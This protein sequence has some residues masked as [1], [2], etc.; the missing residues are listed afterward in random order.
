MRIGII[1]HNYP[2]NKDDR[3][4]AGIF[5]YD[6]AEALRNLGHDV[7]VLSCG[8]KAKNEKDRAPVSWFTWPGF[9]KKLGKLKI[10][11]PGDLIAFMVMLIWGC[12]QTE[13]FIQKNKIDFVIGMWTVPA[14]LFS[15]WGN[16]R[17]KTHYCLW[18]LGSDTY[19]YSRYPILGNL[20]KLSLK[21]AIF[22]LADGID[23]AR[24]TGQIANRP[25]Q[26]LPSASLMPQSEALKIKKTGPVKFMFL[27]RIESV[28]GPDI[29]INTFVKLKD[30]DFKLHCLGDGSLLPTLKKQVKDFGLEKKVIFYGNVNDPKIIQKHLLSSDWLIIPSRGDSIPLVFSES[31]KAGLPVVAAEV[32]DLTELINKYKVGFS[33]PKEDSQ[34]LAEILRNLINKG[35]VATKPYQQRTKKASLIFDINTS[36]RSLIKT[37]LPYL[38]ARQ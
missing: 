18:S 15:L 22:L 16:L 12:W 17:R 2:A 34:K 4:N 38:R 6:F 19:V 37:S 25:C 9:G 26:F 7:F 8:K 35:R 5:V 1:T 21:R 33:F 31:M 24:Q 13:K 3:Q 36:A 32:G 10:F 23:L 11:N 29:L 20:I 30:L 14:G 27:G 28:K